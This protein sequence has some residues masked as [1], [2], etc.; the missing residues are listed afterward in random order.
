MEQD[1]IRRRNH[2]LIDISL[3]TSVPI[4]LALQVITQK[5]EQ[6]HNLS[7]RTNISKSNI[8]RLS[9]FVLKTVSS[10]TT[11]NIIN[12]FQVVPWAPP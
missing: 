1:N 6:D 10:N 3:F 12:K 2:D 11:I 7:N 4:E 9:E 5:L 8:I